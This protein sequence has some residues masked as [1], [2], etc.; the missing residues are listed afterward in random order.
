MNPTRMHSGSLATVAAADARPSGVT[1]VVVGD[2]AATQPDGGGGEGGSS[3]PRQRW[4]LRRAR[5][6][7][8]RDGDAAGAQLPFQLHSVGA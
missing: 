4:Q 3:A 7:S 5:R 1:Y 2:S 6:G 8:V